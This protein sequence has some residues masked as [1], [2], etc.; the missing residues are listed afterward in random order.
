ME[1]TVCSG[2]AAAPGAG[3]KREEGLVSPLTRKV[4]HT[5]K[6]HLFRPLGVFN[7]TGLY[8]GKPR[9]PSS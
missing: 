1:G 8:A 4:I 6:L 9:K 7:R 5:P 3:M 2:N